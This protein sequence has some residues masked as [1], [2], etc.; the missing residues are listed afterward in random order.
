M[1]MEWQLE[2][3][4]REMVDGIVQCGGQWIAVCDREPEVC[5]E[6]VDAFASIAD[7]LFVAGHQLSQK[8]RSLDGKTD[9]A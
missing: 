9:M 8:S 4:L 6:V 3:I 7:V 1:R 2:D 5:D